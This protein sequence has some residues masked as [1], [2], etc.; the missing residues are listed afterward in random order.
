MRTRQHKIIVTL[1]GSKA[2]AKHLGNCPAPEEVW[3]LLLSDE[4]INEIIFHTNKKITEAKNKYKDPS[5]PALRLLDQVEMKTFLGL[6][7][8]TA[9]FKSGNENLDYLFATDGRDVFRC[10]M[11]KRRSEFLLICLRFDSA[12][13]IN[14]RKVSDPSV[15]ISAVFQKL[16]DNF[17]RYYSPGV[18][19]TVDEMIIPF[20]G[21]CKFRIY[22]PNKPAKYGIKVQ[23]LTDT[24]N[25]YVYNAYIYTGK[26]S[27]GHTLSIEEKKFGIRTQSVIRLYK[28]LENSH[29]NVKGDN[30]F[31]SLQLVDELKKKE[32]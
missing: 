11:P 25:N 30:W 6:L 15:A 9:V 19:V 31:S 12:E 14:E 24:R 1:P 3:R 5:H 17:Q 20:R 23:C 26:G 4:I 13:T 22:L 8:Y 21:K 16:I 7:I 27:D 10:T 28:G 32:A 18:N 29:R 2:A